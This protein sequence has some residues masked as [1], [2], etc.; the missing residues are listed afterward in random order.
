MGTP[1]F[2]VPCLKALVDAKHNVQAVFTQPDKPRGRG[3]K[4]VPTPVKKFAIECNIPVYQPTG[5]RKGNDAE[6]SLQVL[7]ELNPDL[8]VVVAYGQILPKSI[9]DLPKYRCI[10]IHASLLPKYRGAGPIQRCILD[11]ETLTGVTSMYMEEGLDTGDMLIKEEITIGKNMIADELHDALSEMGAEVLLKTIQAIEDGSIVRTPQDDS[12][13]TYAKMITKEMSH[14]D[15]SKSAQEVHNIIR[16]ITGFTSLNG[17]RL[18][19]FRSEILEKTSS[20]PFGTI[21]DT[22][23]FTVVCGDGKCI[24][25]NEVQL[26]GSK[27]MDTKVFLRG[28]KLDKTIL[29]E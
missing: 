14:L 9:L 25:F 18:K 6:S 4:L 17:K 29:G 2:A 19:V 21:V 8:I 12:K 15:F 22:S 11:G 13:S 7:Q 28:K 20:E 3:N 5:L 24:K 16:G 1:D 10:N 27:R 26:E 23:N